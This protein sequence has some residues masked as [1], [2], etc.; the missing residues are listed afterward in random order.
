MKNKCP[1]KNCPIVSG[2]DDHKHHKPTHTPT[3][4]NYDKANEILSSEAIY[5]K[6]VCGF[7]LRSLPTNEDAAFIVRAV[8]CHEEL[9]EA[10]KIALYDLQ[11]LG[12]KDPM[13]RPRCLTKA[14]K[15]I[16]EAEGK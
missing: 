6:Y 11:I 8:N 5:P 2:L 3:P 10:L 7:E 4:W 15:A 16:A 12:L 1:E 9:V 13:Y 14:N